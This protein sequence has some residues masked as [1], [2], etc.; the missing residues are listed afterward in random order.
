MNV[1]TP[2][3]LLTNVT[4]NWYWSTRSTMSQPKV[5]DTNL[6]IVGSIKIKSR[7]WVQFRLVLWLTSYYASLPETSNHIVLLP[8]LFLQLLTLSIYS[9]F[10]LHKTISDPFL[11]LGSLDNR[12][13]M[14]QMGLSVGCDLQ[15]SLSWRSRAIHKLLDTSL[16]SKNSE[17][18]L[19]T[20]SSRFEDK[21][22]ETST[23]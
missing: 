21:V 18:L 10:A 20:S 11:D 6:V 17:N 9:L 14:F 1:W 19:K 13:R 23:C 5:T 12:S 3:Q 7:F 4:S 2:T 22:R 16:Y 8:R 15:I